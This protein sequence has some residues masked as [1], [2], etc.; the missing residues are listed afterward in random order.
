MYKDHGKFQKN[1]IIIIIV[2]QD[3]SYTYNSYHIAEQRDQQVVCQPLGQRCYYHELILSLQISPDSTFRMI[4]SL[5][6]KSVFFIFVTIF[7]D[8]SSFSLLL[9]L[10]IAPARTLGRKESLSP[11]C[12]YKRPPN[13]QSHVLQSYL[14]SG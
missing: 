6:I 12:C 5:S 7:S 4:L 1:I 2:I 13:H 11:T 9:L 10:L 3:Y 14:P 8:K